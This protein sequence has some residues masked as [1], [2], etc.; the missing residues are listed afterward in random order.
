[1]EIMFAVVFF[2]ITSLAILGAVGV[3][4]AHKLIY[5]IIY[6]FLTFLCVGF[7][8]ITLELPFLGFSQIILFMVTA[9]SFIISSLM[10]VKSNKDKEE[11]VAFRPRFLFSAFVLTLITFL[12]IISVKY[13]S[14]FSENLKELGMPIII[15]SA[16][17]V[18]VEMFVNYGASFVF[19]TFAF[20]AAVIGFG[21][22][23]QPVGKGK[24]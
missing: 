17:T 21:V 13:S 2:L 14:F 4:S 15:P 16:Q 10:F 19:T 12:I 8:L 9:F 11:G 20:L 3:V 1:M 5:S 23:A 6:G 22:F 24:K 7:L 18:A